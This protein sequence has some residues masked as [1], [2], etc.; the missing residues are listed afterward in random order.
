EQ[1][2]RTLNLTRALKADRRAERELSPRGRERA[3]I[4]Q[5]RGELARQQVSRFL[6]ALEGH[7]Q[8]RRI[9]QRA[10]LAIGLGRAIELARLLEEPRRFDAPGH[11]GRSW[12]LPAGE[13]SRAGATPPG[14]LRRA[15]EG[16]RDRS[17]P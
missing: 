14:A 1:L 8:A 16:G 10:G 3:R 13:T 15:S 7:E 11:E 6:E 2:E 17:R 12:G 5:V 9:G 4:P